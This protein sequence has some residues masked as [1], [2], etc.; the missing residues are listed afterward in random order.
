MA[1]E[2][3]SHA[4]D[5]HQPVLMHANIDERAEVNHVAHRARQLHARRQVAHCEHIRAQHGRGQRLT[6]VT[7]G[8]FQL[9]GDIQQ[10]HFTHTERFR[11][12]CGAFLL[13]AAQHAGH[14]AACKRLQ[15]NAEVLEQRPGSGIALRVH[16]RRIQR[17]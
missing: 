7:S 15:L 14:T 3:V 4:G 6:R 17:I 2:P 1:D 16:S 10:R 9:G 11:Q 13:H 12:L 8:L 5:V